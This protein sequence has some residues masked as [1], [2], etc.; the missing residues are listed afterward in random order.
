MDLQAR[1]AVWFVLIVYC[2]IWP[3]VA[4]VTG[5]M[6]PIVVLM[7]PI[8]EVS[9]FTFEGSPAQKLAVKIGILWGNLKEKKASEKVDETA[10]NS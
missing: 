9:N 6:V 3:I 4:I 7:A 1:I 5:L 10:E 8:E 2:L